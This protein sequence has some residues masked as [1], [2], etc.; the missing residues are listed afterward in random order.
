VSQCLNGGWRNH[1]GT[2]PCTWQHYSPPGWGMG[3]GG[4][5][6]CNM[7]GHWRHT[8]T[9]LLVERVGLNESKKAEVAIGIFYIFYTTDIFEL[10]K[11]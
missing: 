6:H 7:F 4:E 1:Q 2:G 3:V 10:L 8:E 5:P 9:Y 11:F